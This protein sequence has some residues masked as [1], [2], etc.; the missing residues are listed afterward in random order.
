MVLSCP[1]DRCGTEVYQPIAA[2][3][4]RIPRR[5]LPARREA[6]T[7]AAGASARR[8][9][10]SGRRRASLPVGIQN[11]PVNLDVWLSNEGLRTLNRNHPNVH[12]LKGEGPV[13]LV[14]RTIE[15]TDGA[16]DV[17]CGLAGKE[18][19]MSLKAGCVGCVPAP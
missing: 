16:Y 14:Q 11:N 8:D 5:F 15:E 1:P 10:Q 3:G 4:T 6:A 19:P 12:L 2:A 9:G 13:T 7:L 17:F 18:M